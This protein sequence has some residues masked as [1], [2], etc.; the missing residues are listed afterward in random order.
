MQKG[1]RAV[2]FARKDDRKA[3]I[4]SGTHDDVRLEL[5]H[6]MARLKDALGHARACTRELP[7]A[8]LVQPARVYELQPIA[9]FGD[10]VLFDALIIADI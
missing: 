1:F 10:D 4:A 6:D 3:D 7:K 5:S 9:G 2:Q 8:G